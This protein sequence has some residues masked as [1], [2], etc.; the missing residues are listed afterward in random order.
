MDLIN[1]K[2]RSVVNPGLCAAY[3]VAGVA[4]VLLGP[5]L[6]F[7]ST[8]WPINDALAGSLF[9][10]QFSGGILSAILSTRFPR[11][12]FLAGLSIGAPLIAILAW[13]PWSLAPVIFFFLGIGLGS[14][15]G[16]GNILITR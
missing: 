16:A 11:A 5:T 7:L 8:R 6:P 1:R 3:F 2:T 15:V 12:C 10:A 13:A 4:S 9:A 14:I